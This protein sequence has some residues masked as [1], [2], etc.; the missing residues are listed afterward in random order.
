[1]SSRA[2]RSARLLAGVLVLLG[3]SCIGQ[4]IIYP[5]LPT[6][7]QLAEFDAAGP[8]DL[9]GGEL[10]LHGMK[11]AGPYRVIA[12]DLLTVTL[13]SAVGGKDVV[14]GALTTDVRC[15][16]QPDGLV[17]LPLIGDFD[18]G[19][20]T[21]GE[22]EDGL[23]EAYHKDDKLKER[24]LVVVTVTEYATVNVAVI[25]AV[26]QPGQ[27]ALRADQRSV[28][29]ALMAAGGIKSERGAARIRVLGEDGG[30]RMLPVQL[31]D[32]P[33][34]DIALIGGET[35]VVVP[36]SERQFT[37]YGLVKKSGVF[38][39]PAPRRLNLMQALAT[40]GGTDDAAAPRYATIYRVKSDGAI[41]GATFKIDGNSLTDASNVVIKDGD[42]IAVEHTQ[43]SWL[44]AFFTNVFGFRANVSVATSTSP[45]L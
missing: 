43:G 28:L 30:E 38:P 3:T 36:P 21:Q 25:G 1:M 24:P 40:A 10:Q 29:G 39:Y 31:D 2:A 9:V 33:L 22:I 18:V 19:G 34:E 42:V 7:E 12:G 17:F 6:P 37:V 5:V 35:V 27:H 44:R 14:E 4:R 11:V 32:I 20:K 13:P 41:V 26:A 8:E 45:T 16:V 23:A 15:R